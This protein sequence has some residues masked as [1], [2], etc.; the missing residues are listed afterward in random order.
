MYIRN[1][2]H[3]FFGFVVL[4]LFFLSHILSAQHSELSFSGGIAN[5]WGDL[6]PESH[7]DNFQQSNLTL[8]VGYHYHINNSIVLRTD[9][10]FLHLKSEDSYHVNEILRQRN[11]SF[12]ANIWELGI[13]AEIHPL[14]VLSKRR[15]AYSISPYGVIGIAG[16]YYEPKTEYQGTIVKLRP[17]GTEG[18][19]IIGFDDIYKPVGFAI[20]AGI[21]LKFLL[22]DA[23]T[24]SI[25]GVMR[26]TFTDYIDD[27][28]GLYP[29]F[30]LLFAE[31]GPLSAAL[32]ERTDEYLGE[33][34]GTQNGRFEGGQRGGAD[35][36]DYYSGIVIRLNIFLGK[37]L[38][39]PFGMNSRN[40]T[41][42]PAF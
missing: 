18:Q 17:L 7:F 38:K 3:A 20:P 33:A 14:Q 2:K 29:N 12:I 28:S 19:G 4:I 15:S 39:S 26:Y 42:C 32:S 22:S 10:A 16:F 36:T 1:P 9:L 25:E 13:S 34:E 24:L 27:V 35:I 41:I 6:T 31:N 21:G 37:G 40:K 30:D 11:L 8:S 23:L 5:Y